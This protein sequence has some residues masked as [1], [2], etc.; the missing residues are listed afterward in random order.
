MALL[1]LLLLPVLA[2]FSSPAIAADHTIESSANAITASD[3]GAT[4]DEVVDIQK[5]NRSIHVMAMLLVG[6]GFLMV[7]VRNYGL[8][9]ITA[10]FLLVS[11]GINARMVVAVVIRHGR[12]RRNPASSV[13]LRASSDVVIRRRRKLWSR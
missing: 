3:Q 8:S 11:T 9:A 10:T 1:G 12:T 5:Y 2:M 13:A 6:F 7:F 4:I